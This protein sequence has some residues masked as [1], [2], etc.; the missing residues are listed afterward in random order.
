MIIHD[1]EHPLNEKTRIYLRVE[2]LLNQI[3]LSADLTDQLHYLIFF[4]SLFDLAE[5]VEQVQ[6]KSEIAQD[7]EKQRQIYR[8]WRN[9]DGVDQERLEQLLHEV[10]SIYRLLLNTERFGQQIKDDRFLN[11]IRQRFG[12]PGGTCSFDLPILHYWKQQPI[13]QQKQATQ[14]WLNSFLPLQKALNLLLK[15]TR[16]SSDFHHYEATA[17]FFQS[18][19]DEATLLR[20]HIPAEHNAYP[21]ISGNKSRFAIKFIH[22]TSAQACTQ[23]I[24]FQLAI[25]R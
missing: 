12:L 25:C 19:A 1:F 15:L 4:R 24:E 23:N 16:E 10:D 3:Q 13:E 17:G 7:I 9:I 22:F 5:I 18:M 8:Y 14:A 6:L 11:M 20:L 2:S 21:V